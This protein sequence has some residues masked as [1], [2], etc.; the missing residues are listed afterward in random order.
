MLPLQSASR[1]ALRSAC[2]DYKHN[3]TQHN[4]SNPLFSTAQ[5]ASVGGTYRAW[6]EKGW[7]LN[8]QFLAQA[9]IASLDDHDRDSKRAQTAILDGAAKCYTAGVNFRDYNNN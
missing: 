5:G 9:N 3:M 6:L 1:Q 8:R 2:E 7:H 4:R